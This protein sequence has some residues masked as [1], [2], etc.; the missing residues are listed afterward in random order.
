LAYTTLDTL[1]AG[2]YHATLC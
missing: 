1:I 2:F